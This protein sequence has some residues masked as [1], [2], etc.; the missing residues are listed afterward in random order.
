M[1]KIEQPDEI[2]AALD[3]L[4][5][6]VST[7]GQYIG[8]ELNA[9]VKDPAAVD[10]HV[11]LAFPDTYSLGMSHL[12]LQ[13]L[14]A[15][16]NARGD[17][18][19]ERVFAPWPDMEQQMR[20]H[21]VP[22]YSLESRRP[23]RQFDILGF[24]LQYEM[25]YTNVLTM[26]DLAGI[27]VKSA[28]RTADDPLVIA[29]GPGALAP[30]PM[31]DFIDLFVLGDGEG[32]IDELID[33]FKR[34]RR[35][36]T[37]DRAALLRALA[38]EVS[39][40]YAPSLY[41][42]SYNA[43]GTLDT[44]EP[45]HA[46]LPLPV[47]RH[48]VRDLDAA[49]YPERPIVPYVHVVHDRITLEVMRGCAHGCRFC[50]AGMTKRPVRHRSVDRLVQIATRSYAATGHSEMSLASLSTGD[51]PHL[52]ELTERLMAHFAPLKVGLSVP[53]LRVGPAL[54]ELPSMVSVVR[55]TGLTFAPEA[56]SERLRTVI[57]KDITNADL[58]EAC[59]Q[60]FCHGWRLVKLYFMI[61]LPTETESDVMAIVDLARQVSELR[62]QEKGGPAN[63]NVAVSTFVPRPHTPFQW[64]AMAPVDYVRDMQ[65][66]LRLRAGPRRIQ[67]KFHSAERSFLEGVF[68]R[69]DRRLGAVI[70]RAW[71]AGA[72][73][74][75][76]DEQFDFARWQQAFADCS[77][78]PAFYAQRGRAP[79]ELLSWDHI[80]AGVH[81][82]FL[83][84]ERE[85]AAKGHVTP[86]CLGGP[87]QQCG[88]VEDGESC[89][90]LA[91]QVRR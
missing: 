29:G 6:Y 32:K 22:L 65:Q 9:V 24:S 66:R 1:A 48:W 44:I 77:I 42:V 2:T 79:N 78:D 49:P 40:L 90:T 91:Q 60:A 76:W 27:A 52:A 51:Y 59:R 16:L 57:N 37:C 84:A 53:S 8:H 55:K 71:Q 23:V 38:S 12:G 26:L 35:S 67:L 15:I 45:R 63:V 82:E 19:A 13:I 36:G 75:G 43:D 58:F 30:E 31:A 17:C 85:Q 54:W 72:R 81:K 7:P 74:D 46:G 25:S 20:R 62:R 34:L 47:P 11:A 70:L 50:Q 56:A 28:D 86:G 18:L 3:R 87:C 83:A 41:D 21:G 33:A 5:P 4:L 73:F 69:G 88:A 64:E 89:P 80:H 68:A 39:C 10:V 61:G 14:Y